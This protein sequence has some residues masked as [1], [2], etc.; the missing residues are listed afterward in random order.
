MTGHL[1]PTASTPPALRT[2]REL[3]SHTAGSARP[4]SSGS[5]RHVRTP[6]GTEGV[7]PDRLQPQSP[8]GTEV[9]E[10]LRKLRSNR[11]CPFVLLARGRGEISSIPP[12]LPTYVHTPTPPHTR[13]CVRPCT[14][15]R[16]RGVW[17][18]GKKPTPIWSARAR[19]AV[20]VC[21]SR[22]PPSPVLEPH[23]ASL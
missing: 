2:A 14:R 1:G 8:S 21:P 20:S 5:I 15:E 9:P 23:H 16:T 17:T 10:V 3:P 4:N 22:S 18:K 6:A 7:G 13:A 11:I 12:P 19:F